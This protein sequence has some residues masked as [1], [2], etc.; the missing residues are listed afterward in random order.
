MEMGVAST[1]LRPRDLTKIFSWP[2]TMRHREVHSPR[3]VVSFVSRVIKYRQ[4]TI[5]FP[6][7]HRFVIHQRLDS[8]LIGSEGFS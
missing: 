8:N 5:P 4:I 2:S 3:G 7:K 6:E 1:G